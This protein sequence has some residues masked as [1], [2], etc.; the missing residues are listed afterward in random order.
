VVAERHLDP[1]AFVQAGTPVVRLVEAGSLLVQFRVP[2]RHLGSVA[3]GDPLV[4]TTQATGATRFEGRVLRIAGEVSRADRT[5]LVE[6]AIAEPTPVLR[7]GMYAEVEVQLE[8]LR[9]R[10]TVPGPAVVE[11][12][13]A[14][15]EAET[16]VFTVD[17]DEG[18]AR[19]RAVEVVG[20]QGDRVAVEAR[21]EPG[22]RVL[23]LGHEEL[24][25][26][27]PVKV[28]ATP[29]AAAA[30][31]AEAATADGAERSGR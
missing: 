27:S 11:R 31:D 28:V 18:A 21:L 14:G 30:T 5:A 17:G 23:T 9:D 19:W 12:V 26:G 25:D 7:P 10:L 16:G 15:G 4:V 20:R 29:G 8:A 2:E 1:G 22:Q 24:S 13:T 3:P 6:G